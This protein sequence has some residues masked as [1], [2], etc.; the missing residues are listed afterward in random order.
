MFYGPPLCLS[1]TRLLK[2]RWTKARGEVWLLQYQVDCS[3]N[4]AIDGYVDDFGQSKFFCALRV[5]INVRLLHSF[6]A[7]D[8]MR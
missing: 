8:S 5:E 3:L 7:V 2:Y 1:Q 6:T 4:G